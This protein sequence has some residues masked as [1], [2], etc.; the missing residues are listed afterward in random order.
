MRRTVALVPDATVRFLT[1]RDCLD[2]VKTLPSRLGAELAVV[3]QSTVRG[4]IK[5]D[6]SRCCALSDW[7]DGT[8]T[9]MWNQRA[10]FASGRMKNESLLTAVPAWQPQTAYFQAIMAVATPQDAT[11]RRY[12]SMFVGHRPQTP[13]ENTGTIQLRRA[14]AE[15]GSRVYELQ[16]ARGPLRLNGQT[17]RSTRTGYWCDNVVYDG[18][19]GVTFG[20]IRAWLAH[21]CA[22]ES[23]YVSVSKRLT[24][25]ILRRKDSNR[26]NVKNLKDLESVVSS[27]RDTFSNPHFQTKILMSGTEHSSFSFIRLCSCVSHVSSLCRQEGIQ[28][29]RLDC[30]IGTDP[31]NSRQI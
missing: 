4:M 29:L 26:S 19:Y 1:A 8:S 25:P 23:K 22:N 6:M 28:K 13:D 24:N 11:L 16:E 27:R 30:P 14:A 18:K 21:V 7:G 15:T 5:A 3:F 20:S 2:V 9:W 31:W 10:I 12:L 17:S